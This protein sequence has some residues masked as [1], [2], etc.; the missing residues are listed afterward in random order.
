MSTLI[1]LNVNL[2]PVVIKQVNKTTT[3]NPSETL[4]KFDIRNYKLEPPNYKKTRQLTWACESDSTFTY[5]G[6]IPIL[7]TASISA[8]LGVFFQSEA[9]LI[10]SI[11]CTSLYN[12]IICN[13]RTTFPGKENIKKGKIRNIVPFT[14]F[15][16]HGE[17]FQDTNCFPSK[18][19]P[20]FQVL[21]ATL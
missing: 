15:L 11:S 10:P 20:N 2:T 18:V 1:G 6:K 14:L 17:F 5:W 19:C 16:L 13:V 4:D 7:V 9:T 8:T 21:G 12:I 3:R